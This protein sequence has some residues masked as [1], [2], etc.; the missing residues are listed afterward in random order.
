[1][2]E[3]LENFNIDELSNTFSIKKYDNPFYR[4]LVLKIDN[5]AIGYLSYF[6]IYDRIEIEYIYILNEYRRCGYADMLFKR[7]IEIAKN[8]KCINITLEVDVDND[9]AI[10]LYKKNGFKIVSIRKKYYGEND[11]YLM[12]KELEV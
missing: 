8:N 3:I 7:I 2:L 4:I 5:I 12:I 11:G 6:Y 1:M 9:S 10:N